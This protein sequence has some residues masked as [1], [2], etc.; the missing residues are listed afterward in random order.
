[1]NPAERT[2]GQ[3][4]DPPTWAARA[5]ATAP[6]ARHAFLLVLAGPQLG[7][8]VPLE[9]GRELVI[10]RRDDADVTIRD[11]GVSRRH[12][13]IHVEGEGAVLRDLGSANGTWVDGA[14]AA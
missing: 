2:T 5:E 9:P 3:Q 10:G 7:D 8:I 11:D 1:V 14:R 6:D 12:A 4:Q 13:S